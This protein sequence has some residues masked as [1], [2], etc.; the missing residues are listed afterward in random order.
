MKTLGKSC[1]KQICFAKLTKKSIKFLNNHALAMSLISKFKNLK[2][3]W[4]SYARL[5]E[6]GVISRRYF[7]MN[8]FDGIL[9]MFGVIIGAHFSKDLDPA[10]IITAGIAGC[11]AMGVSGSSGAYMTEKAERARELKKLEKAMLKSLEG[12]VHK[13]AG[14]F[15]SI[16]VAIIDGLSPAIFGIM[17]ILPF[18]FANW[19][20]IEEGHAF[21]SS[22]IMTLS[23]LFIL[24]MYLAKIS[25]ENVIWYGIKM[26]VI[27]CIAGT[28]CVITAILLTGSL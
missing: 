11:V 9:T 10:I 21:L 24:G 16:F 25:D 19:E 18:F 3:K 23:L 2:A 20:I 4:K 1:Q 14:K 6:V 27:G 13:E 26:L 8:A 15:A 28:L 7:V 17:V 12:S 5:S 22:I